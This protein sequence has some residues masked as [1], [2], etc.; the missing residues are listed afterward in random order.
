[1]DL[2][3]NG[4]L[5][6]LLEKGNGSLDGWVD[7][8]IKGSGIILFKDNGR[9]KLFYL[10]GRIWNQ[11]APYRRLLLYLLGNAV[12]SNTNDRGALID[13]GTNVIVNEVDPI[14]RGA[15]LPVQNQLVLASSVH[16]FKGDRS[17]FV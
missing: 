15:E 13:I 7:P 14:D 2:N 11:I 6:R 16:V 9:L 17:N 8:F 1:A 5:V 10:L 12:P 3:G 4:S